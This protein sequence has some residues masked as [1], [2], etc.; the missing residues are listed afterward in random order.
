MS[1]K[2]SGPANQEL[3]QSWR[4]TIKIHPAAEMVPPVSKTELAE[5]GTDIKTN[6][7]I[8]P[9]ALWRPSKDA[10]AQLLD[11]RG[12]LDA[13]ELELGRPVRI[14]SRTFRGRTVWDLEADDDDG[15]PVLVT[16]LLGGDEDFPF[17]TRAEST[18]VVLGVDTNPYDFVIAANL[19][20]RHLNGSQKR[21]IVANLI[22]A[23]PEKSNRQIAETAKASP[24]TVGTVRAEMEAKGE[25][26]KLDTRIDAKGVKQPAK[27]KS[28]SEQQ[29]RETSANIGA[30]NTRE[31][32]REELRGH[33]QG[34]DD[35]G[36][37]RDGA[38]ETT[39][40]KHFVA[41][42]MELRARVKELEAQVRD[43]ESGMVKG[44][45][46]EK[47]V[48]EIERRPEAVF[49]KPL[50]AAIRRTLTDPRRHLGPTLELT[51]DPI[52]DNSEAIKLH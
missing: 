44:L 19:H 49:L 26:S 18:L 28:A 6:G 8:S 14:T 30:D 24:T 25:V 32:A 7:L 13:I 45:T 31:I 16:D 47:L 21:D 22:K 52:T 23:Q 35:H 4:N 2:K 12:R 5:L 11:G 36:R 15:D 27:R 39:P 50:L 9:I 33:P 20:R 51:A 10:Q 46:I 17:G 41:Q 29:T 34:D 1:L 42:A 43:L 38:G 3:A 37:D 48:D 40:E